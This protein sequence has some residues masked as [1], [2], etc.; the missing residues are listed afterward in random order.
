MRLRQSIV[1][2]R[3]PPDH[4]RVLYSGS[5]DSI[6]PVSYIVC[7]YGQAPERYERWSL[8]RQGVSNVHLFARTRLLDD[9]REDTFQTTFFNSQRFCIPFIG[10]RSLNGTVEIIRFANVTSDT[11][12][13]IYTPKYFFM[14]GVPILPCSGLLSP[15]SLDARTTGTID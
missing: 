11:E 1:P 10:R 13:V 14:N 15:I 2:D 7:L 9:F 12:V 4:V 8:N 3:G 5:D 6:D